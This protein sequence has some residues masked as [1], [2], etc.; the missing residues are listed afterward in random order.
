MKLHG[1]P[2]S[3][4]AVLGFWVAGASLPAL[5]QAQGGAEG[6][7]RDAV[8]KQHGN[9][10]TFEQMNSGM[11]TDGR[12]MQAAG[13]ARNRRGERFDFFCAF[14]AGSVVRVDFQPVGGRVGSGSGS[15]SGDR[16]VVCESKN[17]RRKECRMDTRGGVR[18]VEQT[19]NT[20]CRQGSNWGFDRESVW[21]DDGCAG[22]F[23]SGHGGG[24][25]R[26][27]RLGDACERA[28]AK[29]GNFS[30]SSVKAEETPRRVSDDVFEFGLRTPGG[31]YVCTVERDGD[32]R[33]VR[34]P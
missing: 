20:R 22:R 2:C 27:E 16:E 18:L 12:N 9:D 32:V 23:R 24:S 11:A 1:I 8:I 17:H 25:D 30:R 15:G 34:R 7:C 29:S 4:M 19:S 6:M 21:V 31:R 3:A 10:Y 28:V 5:A 13:V 14:E 33:R 26:I